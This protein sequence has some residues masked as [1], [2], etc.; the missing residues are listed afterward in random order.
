MKRS[1]CRGQAASQAILKTIA[2]IESALNIEVE[3][4]RT[5]DESRDHLITVLEEGFDPERCKGYEYDT[6]SGLYRKYNPD[7][8]E[9]F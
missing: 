3:R 2:E 1:P 5:P 8:D 4:G 9:F 7:T 6:E